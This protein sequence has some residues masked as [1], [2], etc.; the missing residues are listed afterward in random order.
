MTGE[1]H[2]QTHDILHML[3]GGDRLPRGDG[4]DQGDVEEVGWFQIHAVEGNDGIAAGCAVL[5]LNKLDG[6]AFIGVAA[7]ESFAFQC[8]ELMLH[9]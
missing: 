7:D 4:A 1:T 6:P 2:W 3:L 9:R 8:M 5:C